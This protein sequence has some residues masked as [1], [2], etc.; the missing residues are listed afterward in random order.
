[1]LQS[2][3]VVRSEYASA[4][5][6]A[7]V[8]LQRAL[9]ATSIMHYHT[10]CSFYNY[11][12]P[13]Y[14][15]KLSWSNVLWQLCSLSQW[16]LPK[17]NVSITSEGCINVNIFWL[18]ISSFFKRHLVGWTLYKRNVQPTKWHFKNF[19]IQPIDNVYTTFQRDTNVIFPHCPLGAVSCGL[20]MPDSLAM[21]HGDRWY[22]MVNFN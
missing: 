12:L 10:Y 18:N 22:S 9:R 7:C 17:N 3:F 14:R 5:S 6:Y 1:M 13:A 11:F 2:M 20:C 19:H 21:G 16:A 8:N 4:W 15:L